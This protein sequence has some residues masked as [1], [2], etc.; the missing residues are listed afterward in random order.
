MKGKLPCLLAVCSHRVACGLLVLLLAA[1]SVPAARGDTREV[2]SGLVGR[3]KA[4]VIRRLGPPSDAV[5][6]IDGERLFYETLDAGR[7]GDR[8][9]QA[10]RANEPSRLGPSFRTYSF[11]CKTEVVI[12]DGRV[13][14]FNRNGND[15]H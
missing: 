1:V 11:H 8:S 7:I 5:T 6:T 13:Q 9:G 2:L 10:T 12:R 4:E 14:A 3:S 15:C